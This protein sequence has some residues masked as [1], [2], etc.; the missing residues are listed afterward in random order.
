VDWDDL[1]ILIA[2]AESGSIDATARSLELAPHVV[3]GRIH[4][5]EK[6][7]NCELATRSAGNVTF[8]AAGQRVVALAREFASKLAALTAELGGAATEVTGKVCVTSTAGV[9]N[10]ANPLFD[11]LHDEYPALQISTLLSTQVVDL[12]KREADIAI[13]M[14]RDAQA[15]YTLRK[16]GT[17]GWSMYA[18]QQYLATHKP[19]STLVEGHTFIAYDGNFSNT[20]AGRWIAANVPAE[21]IGSH[22]GGI[23]QAFDAAS[24]HNGVCVVPCYLA[25]E[26]PVVRVTDQVVT[27][28]DVFAVC[29]T[30]RAEEL[31]LKVVSD[32]LA[33][34]FSRD[35]VMF[36][37]TT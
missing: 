11:A 8:T 12:R 33:D 37:G 27:T 22:V 13:R 6:T 26:H 16:L 10:R 9:I 21:A 1:K 28:N 29:L 23:R 4:T 30:S 19:G 15:D 32:R 24:R 35:Q 7:M 5:L 14:F 3:A 34:M 17:I 18:S 36:A 20:A 2:V 25:G 31:R